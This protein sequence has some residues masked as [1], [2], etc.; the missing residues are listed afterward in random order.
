MKG[1]SD[2]YY[3]ETKVKVKKGVKLKIVDDTMAHPM[4]GSKIKVKVKVCKH[5]YIRPGDVPFSSV[6][7]DPLCPYGCF[8]ITRQGKR[9]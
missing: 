6:M 2:E 5:N 3:I 1:L 4:C 7:D 9:R 8:I